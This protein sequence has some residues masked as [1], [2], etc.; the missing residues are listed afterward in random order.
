M[1]TTV[2]TRLS[3]DERSESV[4]PEGG[5]TWAESDTEDADG[6]AKLPVTETVMDP[7]WGMATMVPPTVEFDTLSVAGHRAPAVAMHVAA[8]LVAPPGRELVKVAPSD[9]VRLFSLI[10]T[11]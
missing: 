6:L 7:R 8:T 11:V 1:L 2:L 9:A 3:F 4:A 10:V 5:S